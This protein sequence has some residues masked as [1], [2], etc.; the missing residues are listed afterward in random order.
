VKNRFVPEIL[1][2]SRMVVIS[3]SLC[4]FN[5]LIIGCHLAVLAISGISYTGNA[6]TLHVLVK[7][8]KSL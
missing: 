7:N 5:K 1:D 4:K 2:K 6:K 3:S 8:N